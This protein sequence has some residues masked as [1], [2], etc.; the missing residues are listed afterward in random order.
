LADFPLASTPPAI[1][2]LANTRLRDVLCVGGGLQPGCP[3]SFNQ[4]FQQ[5]YPDIGFGADNNRADGFP[6]FIFAAGT[7]ANFGV[8]SLSFPQRR[9]RNTF[10]FGNAYSM[11][12]GWHT[13]R[14]GADV[15]RLQQN[16]ISGFNLRPSFIVPDFSAF[17]FQIDRVLG[18]QQN[19]FFTKD[20][21]PNGPLGRGL[22]SAE[23]GLFAQTN[24]KLLPN[25]TIDAGLRYEL[26]GRERDVD[27][28]LS[29]AVGLAFENDGTVADSFNVVS[30]GQ[31][32][33]PAARNGDHDNFAPRVGIAW[34]P[35]GDLK[36]A[37]RATYGIY[38]D[39][40]QGSTIFANQLNPPFVRSVNFPPGTV[41]GDVPPPTS[42]GTRSLPP[43]NVVDPNIR[44]PFAQRWSLSLQREI[45]RD[46]VAEVSYVG[47]KGTRLLRPRTPNLGPF[48]NRQTLDVFFPGQLARLNQNFSAITVQESSASSIYHA[49]QV[50]VQ[51]RLSRGLALQAAYTVSR[52]LDDVS[53]N[54]IPAGAGGSVFP[55]NSFDL[56]SERGLSAF[57]VRQRLVINYVYD[58]PFG[59][60][61][62]VGGS[63]KGVAARLLEG[64]SV[65][66]IVVF[67]KGFPLTLTASG[68][69]INAD[70]VYND[71]P[72]LTEGRSVRELLAPG[73]GPQF[74]GNPQGILNTGGLCDGAFIP[75]Q[76]QGP[77]ARP[78]CALFFLFPELAKNFRPPV[79]GN[80][81]LRPFDPNR[82]LNRGVF[83]GPG[84]SKFDFAV[85]KTTRLHERVSLEFRAE[86]FNLL[87][88]T[89]FADPNV[90][91]IA[92]DFGVIT[93][94]STP[95]RQ[96]QFALKLSF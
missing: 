7:F 93:E 24:F 65:S 38:Y 48:V 6:F 68:V 4:T 10:Q 49:A 1:Q 53:S 66:G 79:Y 88:H 14:I 85:R 44:D 35:F 36:T 28:F 21:Q 57:D 80:D 15:R 81:L 34:D 60:G 69:D 92:P 61:Q 39:H 52:S 11:V 33:G 29:R 77:T 95:A 54:V 37:V 89:N 64:W 43:A 87:N 40:I 96:I 9:A 12:R 26:F 62:R 91:M 59:R 90:N 16:A 67:Q 5:V 84:R 23:L 58:L 83:I 18:G 86:I 70:G 3:A 8:D 41:L 2:S 63:A 73:R 19:F 45:A 71:R 75:N 56:T 13:I 94:P 32:A 20:G 76:L 25:L 30:V 27:D 47:S 50:N 55:Q 46:T 74:F 72:F 22:R 51:R 78:L 82:Q 42:Q 17:S 31:Q